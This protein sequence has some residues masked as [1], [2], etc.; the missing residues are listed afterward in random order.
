VAVGIG[1][2]GRSLVPNSSETSH[3][4]VERKLLIGR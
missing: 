1:L 4:F 2:T 3:G